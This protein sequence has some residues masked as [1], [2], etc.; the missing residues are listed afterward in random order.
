MGENQERDLESSM[1]GSKLEELPC[2]HSDRLISLRSPLR[3][4]RY[5]TLLS[6]YA[7]MN[8]A[9]DELALYLSLTDIIHGILLDEKSSFLVILILTL[10]QTGKIGCHRKTWGWKTER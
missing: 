3:K 1:L 7:P 5:A 10:L 6:T 8:S 9:K 2:G 4:G